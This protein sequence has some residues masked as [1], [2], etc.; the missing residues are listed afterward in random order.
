MTNSKTFKLWIVNVVS[1]IFFILLSITG[2]V[3]WFISHTDLLKSLSHFFREVH[4]MSAFAF[5]ILMG[6][7]LFMHW[8]YVMGNL[9]KYNMIKQDN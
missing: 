1:F 2:L 5:I 3:I 6:I 7:H 9:R 8:D 4:E